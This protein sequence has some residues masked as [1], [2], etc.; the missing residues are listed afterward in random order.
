M[1]NLLQEADVDWM[2]HIGIDLHVVSGALGLE[3]T[4]EGEEIRITESAR[5]VVAL[6][7]VMSGREELILGAFEAFKREFSGERVCGGWKVEKSDGNEAFVVSCCLEGT[8]GLL[9]LEKFENF[10]ETARPVV[11]TVDVIHLAPWTS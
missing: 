5:R 4:R 11:V 3:P 1:I 7:S 10:V 2:F 8:Q 9:Q 6:F